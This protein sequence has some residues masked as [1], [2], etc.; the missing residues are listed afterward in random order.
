MFVSESSASLAAQAM[1]EVQDGD[2]K[3]K[4]ILAIGLYGYNEPNAWNQYTNWIRKATT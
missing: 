3:R 4:T 1:N 2:A